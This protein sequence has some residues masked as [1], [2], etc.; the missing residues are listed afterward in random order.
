MQDRSRTL[1]PGITVNPGAPR[2]GPAGG[3]PGPRTEAAP[4]PRA[5]GDVVGSSL[6]RFIG[7]WTREQAEAVNLALRDFD[8]IDH[9]MWN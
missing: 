2:S 9:A 8:S 7:S 5:P 3:G 1:R 6:D 4:T